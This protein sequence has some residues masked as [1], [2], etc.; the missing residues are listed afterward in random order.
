MACQFLVA[1]QSTVTRLYRV[2][3]ESWWQTHALLALSALQ[4]VNSQ[5]QNRKT[6]LWAFQA[7]L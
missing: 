5:A 6:M 7:V 1:Q 2:V 4:E 3:K